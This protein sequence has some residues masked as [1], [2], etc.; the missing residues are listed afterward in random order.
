MLFVAR[1]VRAHGLHPTLGLS[2]ASGLWAYH[3]SMCVAHVRH[4]SVV[5][6]VE[7]NKCQHKFLR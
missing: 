1:G 3:T 6:D 5:V 7:I 4:G 2:G